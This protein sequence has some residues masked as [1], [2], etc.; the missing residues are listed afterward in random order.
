MFVFIFCVSQGHCSR[1]GHVDIADIRLIVFQRHRAFCRPSQERPGEPAAGCRSSSPVSPQRRASSLKSFPR[2]AYASRDAAHRDVSQ[3]R[4]P[5]TCPFSSS[6]YEIPFFLLR[7]GANTRDVAAGRRSS[8][9]AALAR[10]PHLPLLDLVAG[11]PVRRLLPVAELRNRT[12]RPA[13][14]AEVLAIPLIF[15]IVPHVIV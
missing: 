3:M 14:V 9:P 6:P 12:V 2:S 5:S 11:I 4:S 8:L 7:R 1:P 10:A 13:V 15:L